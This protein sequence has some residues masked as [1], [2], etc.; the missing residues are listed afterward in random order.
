MRLAAVLLGVGLVF[1]AS[2]WGADVGSDTPIPAIWKEQHLSF[3]YMGRTS[4]YSCDGLRLSL[5]H[6]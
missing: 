3:F 5:I 4:R 1:A 2:A 6:I